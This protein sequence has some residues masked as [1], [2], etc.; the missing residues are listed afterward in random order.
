M[1]SI[2]F[3]YVVVEEPSAEAALQ[4][5]LPRLLGEVPFQVIAF[6]DKQEL[7]GKLPVRLRGWACWL[8][9]TMRVV[10]LVDLDNDDCHALKGM[11]EEMAREAGLSTRTVAGGASGQ[12]ANRIVIEELEAWFIGDADAVRAAFPGV[13]ATFERN[14]SLRDPDAVR[15]GTWEALSRVL[16]RAGYFVTGYRKITAARAI[17]EHMDPERNRSKSFQVFRD[18]C[19]EWGGV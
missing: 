18:A 4:Y 8:P 11:L 9:P 2:D 17:A 10:V 5:L 3:V 13:S 6:H 12:V 1:D 19:R 7:L 14:R 16:R 15:G